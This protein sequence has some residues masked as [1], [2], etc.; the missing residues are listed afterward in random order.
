MDFKQS[1]G[2]RQTQIDNSLVQLQCVKKYAPYRC[3]N[4]LCHFSENNAINH[5]KQLKTLQHKQVFSV[6]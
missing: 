3:Y 5:K 1:K 2:L 6:L 4:L